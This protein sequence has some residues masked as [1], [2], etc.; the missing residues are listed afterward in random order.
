MDLVVHFT[1]EIATKVFE[2][3]TKFDF[4][5]NFIIYRQLRFVLEGTGRKSLDPKRHKFIHSAND[6]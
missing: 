1:V 3:I 4:G 5:E 6:I 2:G